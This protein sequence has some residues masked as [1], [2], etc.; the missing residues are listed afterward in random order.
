[1]S[2]YWL[3]KTFIGQN[4]GDRLIWRLQSFHRPCPT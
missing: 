3:G 1:M 2:A 4:L